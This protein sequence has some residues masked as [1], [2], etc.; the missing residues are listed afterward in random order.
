MRGS[1]ALLGECGYF[2]WSVGEKCSCQGGREQWVR[3]SSSKSHFLRNRS[4][5]SNHHPPKG[6]SGSTSGHTLPAPGWIYVFFVCLLYL[7]QMHKLL[8]FIFAIFPQQIKSASTNSGSNITFLYDASLGLYAAIGTF[9]IIHRLLLHPLFSWNCQS[10]FLKSF[11]CK[12]WKT[13]T[14]RFNLCCRM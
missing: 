4:G 14:H 5:R 9:L 8:V 11:V 12:A 3:G 1:S 2:G 10:R 6:S 13:H 7:L